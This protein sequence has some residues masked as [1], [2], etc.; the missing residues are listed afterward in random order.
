[1]NDVASLVKIICLDKD[2]DDNAVKELALETLIAT[3][4]RIPSVLNNNDKLI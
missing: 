3:I 2:I 4:E 1:M